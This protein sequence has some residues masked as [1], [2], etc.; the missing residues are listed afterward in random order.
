MQ[1]EQG[2]AVL[3]E[4]LEWL[5]HSHSEVL[6]LLLGPQPRQ[7]ALRNDLPL[8]FRFPESFYSLI[9]NTSRLTSINAYS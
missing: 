5:T 3:E 6:V 4:E 8:P 1:T 7:I 9:T 2:T